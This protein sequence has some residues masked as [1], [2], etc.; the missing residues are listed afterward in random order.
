MTCATNPTTKPSCRTVAFKEPPGSRRGIAACSFFVLLLAGG[1]L[2]C[3]RDAT[4]GA[5]AGPSEIVQA[6]PAPEAP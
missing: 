5:A 2:G 6:Q 4:A 3:I 1:G